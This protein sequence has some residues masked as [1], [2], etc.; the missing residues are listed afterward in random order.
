MDFRHLE[1]LVMQ[2]NVVIF[3]TYRRDGRPQQSLVTVGVYDG[4]LAFTTTERRAKAKNL[5]RDPRC[6]LMVVRPDNRAYAVLDGDAEI[7]DRTSGSEGLRHTLRDIYRSAAGRDHPDWEEFDRVMREE[8]RLA[9]ILRPGRLFGH[10]I[11]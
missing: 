5:R 9:V 8:E 7:L 11:H 4:G 2:Q 1:Q 10:N 3:T 6:A